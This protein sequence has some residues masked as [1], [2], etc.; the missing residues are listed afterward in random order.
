[1]STLVQIQLG[2]IICRSTIKRY[3]HLLFSGNGRYAQIWE[4][5]KCD[6][7]LGIFFYGPYIHIK[8]KSC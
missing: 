5:I 6:K 7:S 3:N 2:P 4:K 1:M 8:F